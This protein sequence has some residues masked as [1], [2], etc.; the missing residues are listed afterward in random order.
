[1]KVPDT[2]VLL[3]A[4]A[5]GTPTHDRARSWLETSLR[6]TETIGFPWVVLLG[7]VRIST[8]PRIYASPLTSSLALE[9]V[10]EWLGTGVGTVVHPGR[11]H[12]A[13]LA[14]LLNATGTGGNLTTDVHIAA[15][16]LEN[17]ATVASFDGDFHR[18]GKLRF[19]YLG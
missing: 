12:S 17:G 8:N 5:A 14:D 16:G 3:G 7:F 2:N 6:G 9:Q 11:E 10:D 19:E 15:I 4:R 18:F 1:M 13:L